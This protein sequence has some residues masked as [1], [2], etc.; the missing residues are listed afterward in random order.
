MAMEHRELL[1]WMKNICIGP[2]YHPYIAKMA[3][4][5]GHNLITSY[6]EDADLYL[7]SSDLIGY[8][9]N[10]EGYLKNKNIMSYIN[11]ITNVELANL[12]AVPSFKE[13]NECISI[14]ESDLP[15]ALKVNQFA[16]CHNPFEL[17][18]LL[19]ADNNGRYI[20]PNDFLYSV[21]G[22]FRRKWYMTRRETM[23]PTALITFVHQNDSYSKPASDVSKHLI[24][25]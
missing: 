18:L 20:V 16:F 5:A 6:V 14:M 4:L 1:M 15:L 25:F 13:V 12:D 21:K 23:T 7:L 17:L 2:Y 11:Y 19:R 9:T 10:K 24:T 22:L 8:K 3:K